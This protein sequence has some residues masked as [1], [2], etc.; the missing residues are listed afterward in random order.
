VLPA[1]FLAGATQPKYGDEAVSHAPPKTTQDLLASERRFL[2]AMGRMG[3][4]RFESLRIQQGE[5]VLEPWPTAVRT[6]KFG[7][8]TPNR[9]VELSGDF[10][11]KQET[12]QLFE[13]V[14]GV[15]R[16]AIRV[17]EIRGG[18]PFL[19]EALD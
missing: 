10:E 15:E 12:A 2:A 1:L 6:V 14:R 8:A 4:G 7:A 13:F 16:G 18:L 11:L 17:L 19:M 9:R 3:H 5:L